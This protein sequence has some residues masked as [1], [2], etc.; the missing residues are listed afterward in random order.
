LRHVK[1]KILLVLAASAI[2]L[3]TGPLPIRARAAPAAGDPADTVRQVVESLR[4]LRTTDDSAARANQIASID[5]ALAVQPLCRQAL[6]AQWNRISASERTRFVSMIKTLLHKI[7]YPKAAEFF[8]GLTVEY[9]GERPIRGGRIVDTTVRR[10]DGG[11]VS[12]NYVMEKS[13][14]RWKIRD[15][16]LDRQSLAASVAGQIQG[17]LMQGS[18]AE[19]VRQMEARIEQNGS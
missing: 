16:L 15:I 8:S 1:S 5:A 11:E 13:D 19:L 12:I 17:V 4:K 10:S 7:A 2:A 9:R 14:E 3:A 18:F 6:G